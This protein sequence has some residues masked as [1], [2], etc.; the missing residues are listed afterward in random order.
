MKII[1]PPN[2]IPIQSDKIL[3][4]AGSI[5]MDIA[6]DWQEKVE[7]LLTDTD[8]IIL[9]PRRDFWDK[10][11]FQDKDNAQFREQ[12]EW[13]LL[14]QESAHKI[15]MYFDPATKSP[16]SL[17]ELGLFG[18]DHEKMVVVCPPGFWR[19]GNVD[20]VCERYSIKQAQTIE[21]AVSLI[22]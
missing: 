16:V 10:T 7:R 17:L 13:E 19:K 14:G 18:K 6:E 20:V 11:W 15:I 12:V 8:W 9:N 1:K 5:E 2:Q 4:L 21:E 3:F 22:L